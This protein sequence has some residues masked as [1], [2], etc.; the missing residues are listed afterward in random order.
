MGRRLD[1]IADLSGK[2]G[3]KE[4]I[5]GKVREIRDA[6]DASGGA[7]KKDGAPGATAPSKDG[8]A[9]S[10]DKAASE[11]EPPEIAKLREDLLKPNDPADEIMLKHTEQLTRDEVST[12][13]GRRI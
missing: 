13:T 4:T 5:K 8:A 2:P 12:L 6:P 3:W 10:E 7:D 1:N 11:T 9:A